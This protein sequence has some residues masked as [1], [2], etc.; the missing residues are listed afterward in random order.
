MVAEIGKGAELLKDAS[1]LAN[2]T[3]GL[4]GELK[5]GEELLKE[6]KTI[7]GAH[8]GIQTEK[9][10]RV[11]DHLAQDGKKI[12]NVET[13]VG[14]AA[15]SASQVAKDESMASKGGKIVGKNAPPELRGQTVKIGT[16]VRKQ[17]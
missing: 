3:K 7:L 5:T 10:L 17:P 1:V 6:G 8:V 4:A 14:K 13:K 12:L 2:R 15:R 16:N 11:A 9:G